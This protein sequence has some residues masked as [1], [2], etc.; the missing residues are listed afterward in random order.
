VD[1]R[2]LEHFGGRVYQVTLGRDVRVAAS[3]AAKVNDVIKLVT[4]EE[5]TFADPELAGQRLGARLDVGPRRLLVIDD[6]WEPEQLAP[7]TERGRQCVRL[8]TTRIPGLLAGRG[9]A[10]RVDQMSPEQSR[11]LLTYELPP[12]NATVA[13]TLLALTGRWPLL[14]RMANKILANAVGAEQDVSAA[15]TT[16]AERLR[17]AGPTAADHL[18]SVTDLD[19]NL[20]EQRARAVRATIEASTSLLKGQDPERF[21]ELAVFAE[22]EL[23]P[24]HLISRL[25]HET[26]DLDELEAAQ[27]C[28]RLAGLA[29]VTLQ[30]TEAGSGGLMLHDVV[31]DFLRAELGADQ[32]AR[33]HGVLLDATAATLPLADPLGPATMAR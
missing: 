4:D 33:L 5:A 28:Q 27:V 26:G 30:P 1:Q 29:L 11:S 19:I 17:S 14:L 22:D 18:L 21:A 31:R 15:G 23:I 2:V 7:F 32:L 10:I 8:V 3:V 12:L 24:F 16:L 13:D 25:W 6:V 9:T 20:P